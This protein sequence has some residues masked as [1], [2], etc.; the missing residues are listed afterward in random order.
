MDDIVNALLLK[1]DAVLLAR[2]SPHRKA[3]PGLWSFPGGHVQAGETLEQALIREIH[4]EMGIAILACDALGRIVGPHT[5]TEPVAFHIYAVRK[6]QGEPCIMDDEHTEFGWF[7]LEEA[8]A[9]PDLALEEYRPL[10]ES[11][12]SADA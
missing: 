8:L 1:D 4:E 5:S 6:W 10:L 9:L 3:Y 12:R 7:R 2:R 11:L